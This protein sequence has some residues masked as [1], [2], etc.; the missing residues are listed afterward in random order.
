M[1]RAAMQQYTRYFPSFKRT[2]RPLTP[3]RFR[4]DSPFRTARFLYVGA[5]AST[6]LAISGNSM[7]RAEQPI[8]LAD[9]R[10]L[11]VD[12]HVMD[13]TS[14]V[15]W[16]LCQPHDEG[17]VLAFDRP[18]EGAF[19]GYATVVPH[20]GVL[21][22]YYRGLPVAGNDESDMEVTCYAESTDGI[23]WTKPDLG[24][25]DVAGSKQNNVVLANLA[26]C[27]HNFSPLLDANPA[28]SPEDRFK[29]LAVTKRGDQRGLL[30]FA[31]ADG[32]RWRKLQ[33]A[34]VILE[35]GWA[36]DSQNVAFWSVAENK[37][38]AY[39]RVFVDG[40]RS[41]A[42]V[43]SDDF[44][45]WSKPTQMSYS[46]TDSAVP[47]DHLYT[48][49]TQPYFRAPHI[50]ISTAGRFVPGRRVVSDEQAVSLGVHPSYFGDV[51]DVILMSSRGGGEYQRQFTDAFI[52]PGIGLNNWVSR[53][54]FP[55]L[56]VVSSGPNE[57][58]LYVQSD[59]GQPSHHLRRYSMR[60]DGFATM[61]APRS[62][63]ELITKPLT[64][65][66]EQLHL[67][68]STS[69]AGDVRVEIQDVEGKPLPSYGLSDTK[70]LIGNEID[71]VYSWNNADN[72][73]PL[74]GEPVRLRFLLKD[75]E[76]FSFQ[77]R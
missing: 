74:I 33:D 24:L 19:C 58:S 29:A 68:Y 65:T 1:L 23:H 27:S 42:R 30:A 61:R 49:Q 6:L 43:E 12:S 18:W 32:L 67:N 31:S 62:G 73:K 75:A 51:S 37:Y 10:E 64:F 35:P 4:G 56:N 70:E 7:M 59:Y 21:S 69:A 36:F 25:C 54:N 52:K 71:G 41:V 13:Q 8:D 9:R 14:N 2:R 16:S 11:F 20:D 34:P 26:P 63:G 50:Y 39:Y 77:F 17:K 38:V 66:G 22:L 53:T 46:D 60:T 47:S 5:L 76:L 44:I 15:V 72:V 3:A 48:S 55:A 40:V 45:H 28:A 57:M